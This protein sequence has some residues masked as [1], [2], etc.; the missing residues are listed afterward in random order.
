M[1]EIRRIISFPIDKVKTAG[2]ILSKAFHHD[3]LFNYIIPDSKE[4]SKTIT[5][6]FQHVVKY[7]IRYGEVYSS[8]N[9]ECISVWFPPKDSYYTTWKAIKTGAL[10]LPLKVK[11]KYLTLQNKFHKFSDSL[12][13]KLVPYPH[14]YLSVIGVD[15]NRQGEGLGSHLI[16]TTIKR[17][18]KEHKPIYLETNLEKNVE[19]YKHFGFHVLKKVKIPGTKIFQW[20]LLRNPIKKK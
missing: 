17:I 14:W 13:K 11:W 16:S 20:C 1:L 12:H 19:I 5:H 3:P 2:K 10:T 18:D 7:C 8:S 4:R 6:L 15:P 9:L